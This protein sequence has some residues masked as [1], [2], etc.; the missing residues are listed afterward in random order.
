M[1]RLAMLERYTVAMLH[2][3][4]RRESPG[5]HFGR[6]NVALY[7][8]TTSNANVN[9]TGLNKKFLVSLLRILCS[10]SHGCRLDIT[11]SRDGRARSRSG[12]TF[13]HGWDRAIR[14]I[15]NQVR[16]RQLRGPLNGSGGLISPLWMRR[17]QA[18]TLLSRS[19]DSSG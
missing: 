5:K 8:S 17:S 19:R 12:S 10:A 13:D 15:S 11:L 9:P 1:H 14:K 4:L 6:S 3:W 16:K 2:G 18:S 7:H